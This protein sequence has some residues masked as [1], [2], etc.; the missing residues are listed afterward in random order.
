MPKNKDV[1]VKTNRLI[2]SI[3]KLSIQEIRL[4]QLAIV[5]GRSKDAFFNA[6]GSIRSIR[7]DAGRYADMFGLNWHTAYKQLLQAEKRLF[8]RYF[9]VLEP[10]YNNAERKVS[11]IQDVLYLTDQSSIQVTFSQRLV[12]EVTR[13][14]GIE[15]IFSSYSL[16]QTAPLDSEYSVR[17]YELM[18]SWKNFEG[19]WTS[20]FDL[21]TFRGQMGLGVNEY[22][23][24]CDFK[25]RVLDFAV[26]EVNKKT[27]LTISYKQEKQG[28]R[29]IGFRFSV[30]RK[31]EEKKPDT[32]R[33]PNTIDWINGVTDNEIKGMNI[34]QAKLFASLL[35][36]NHEIVGNWGDCKDY[37][38]AQAKLQKQLQ[39]P[40]FVR[41][42]MK[43]LLALP[44][45]H[46]FDPKT[47]GFN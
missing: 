45:P 10:E 1:V 25:R 20:M 37:S 5:E 13:I 28:R 47:L 31:N 33:D 27:D 14:D 34:S 44:A 24:M 21:E 6:D 41:K 12:Q 36:D 19:K 23:R 17:L 16:Q 32:E 11:W 15:T 43:H 18:A 38:Q 46:T 29:I 8:G 22:S 3:Q 39:D 26:K 7:I 42:Y 9:F 2:R 4:I 30:K 35:R 40:K